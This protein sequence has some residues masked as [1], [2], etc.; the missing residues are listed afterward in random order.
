MVVTI[1]D[2]RY[3]MRCQ[4]SPYGREFPA[5]IGG[6]GFDFHKTHQQSL[7]DL[8]LPLHELGT[9]LMRSRIDNVQAALNN[10]IFADPTRVAIHDLINRNPWGV[11]RT[12]PGTKPGEGVHIASVPDVTRGHWNDIAMIGDMKQRLSAASDAQQ[13]MPTS[14][15]IRSATEIQRL[16]QMGSQR[17]GVLSRVISSTSIR[18]MV[19]M[20]ASNI[21]DALRY[22]ESIKISERDQN[23]VLRGMADNGYVDVDVGML[24]GNIEYLVV[25]GTL[26]IEPTRSPETWM[27][28]LQT[29]SQAGLAMEYD[30]GRLVEESIRSMGVPDVDQFRVD[31]DRIKQEGL[32]PH[33]RLALMEKMRGQSSVV[34]QE[35]IE[36]QLT[37][38][39]IV[40]MRRAG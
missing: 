22:N 1:I 28:I 36:K 33:M 3:V 6:F 11:V 23:T 20:M 29:V 26:P 8:L 17:L 25:D 32:A 5:T 19:R 7:Y 34:P 37:A 13:G 21:Q 35:N 12:L 15:G 27:Q 24:Q 39:N 30:M 40:P 38:G 4:L 31:Q 2:E 16:S 14:D 9:W 18:P 10:L